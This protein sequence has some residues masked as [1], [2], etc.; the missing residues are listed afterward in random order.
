MANCLH[1]V[2]FIKN[3]EGGLSKDTADSASA[4]PVPDGSGYHTNKGI[5]WTA[6]SNIFGTGSDSISRFY[7]MS[8]QDW[9][10]L[11]K[12]PFWD[13]ILGDQ[14]QSQ[15]IA[16]IIVDW[17]WGSGKHYPELDIQIILNNS[18][19]Q[20]L[21]EDGSFGNASVASINSA[22]EQA[23]WDAIVAKRFSYL[24]DITNYSVNT[25]KAANPNCTQSDLILHTDLR[26][27]NGWKNRMNN[28]IAFETQPSL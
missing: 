3:A 14:I 12:Q 15:R 25:Y 2:P 11:F 24:D 13:T 8:D 22:N 5:T 10:V 19:G 16:D 27:I 9:M 23:E 6:W 18:F 26:F 21:A 1:V 4:N 28:L 17:V 20:H 7:A